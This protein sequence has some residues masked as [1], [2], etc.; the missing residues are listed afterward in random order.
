M[1]LSYYIV[2]R[3]IK[4]HSRFSEIEISNQKR[5]QISDERKV[6]VDF[7]GS[8]ETEK[9]SARRI[10]FSEPFSTLVVGRPNEA[11]VRSTAELHGAIH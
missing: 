4:V 1:H 11:A 3:Y 7:A 2:S 6:A 9:T 5:E 8:A 10:Y